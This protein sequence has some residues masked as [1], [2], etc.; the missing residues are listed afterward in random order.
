MN[1]YEKRV[2]R[3][4][5]NNQRYKEKIKRQ[6]EKR[7]NAF[8]KYAKVPTDATQAQIDECC[9]RAISNMTFDQFHKIALSDEQYK[10][11]EFLLAMYASNPQTARCF[12]SSN[13]DLQ[14]NTNFMF[15]Y[16]KHVMKLEMQHHSTEIEFWQK[17]ELIQALASYETAIQNSGLFE[18]LIKEYPKIN[19]LE[20]IDECFS[21]KGVWGRWTKEA[22]KE[23]QK[24]FQSVVSGLSKEA[25]ISQ[26]QLFGKKALRYIPSELDFWSDLASAGIKKDG[27]DSLDYL[28][29]K[30]VLANKQLIIE[31]YEKDGIKKL[32]YYLTHSLSPQ[33][34]HYYMCHGEEHSYSHYDEEY[35]I[36]QKTLMN[37]PEFIAILENEENKMKVPSYIHKIAEGSKLLVHENPELVKQIVDEPGDTNSL[38]K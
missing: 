4:E 13:V 36:V 30:D 5:K 1:K 35:E 29:I 26:A 24:Q 25:L 3:L 32:A 6:R 14:N 20:V 38:S 23:N 2:A 9:L 34:T 16:L 33:R 10:N 17:N 21:R 11:P 27:F 7:I 28:P 18:L 12:K 15:E 37:D 8:R 22:L 31:A 19:M